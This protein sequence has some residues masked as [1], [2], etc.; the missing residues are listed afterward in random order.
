MGQYNGLFYFVYISSK[1]D[2][3]TN[4]QILS[5]LSTCSAEK[6][7]LCYGMKKVVKNILSFVI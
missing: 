5:T 7:V 6:L 2:S 1:S 4:F 3:F